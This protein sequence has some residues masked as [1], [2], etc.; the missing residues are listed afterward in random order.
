MRNLLKSIS[1]LSLS[2]LVMVACAQTKPLKNRGDLSPRVPCME[3]KGIK[4]ERRADGF[5]MS[6]NAWDKFIMFC[7]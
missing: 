5:Y 4:Y 7:S 6:D 3:Q 2:M 1:V